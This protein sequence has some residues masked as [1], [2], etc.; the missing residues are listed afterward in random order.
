MATKAQIRNEFKKKRLSLDMSIVEDASRRVC[1]TII[2]SD[3]YKNSK[4]ILAYSSIQNEINLDYLISQAINDN[5]LVY[6]PKVEGDDIFFYKISNLD[7]LSTGSY[8]ILEPSD[9]ELYCYNDKTIILVPGIA[10]SIDGA[11]IGFGKGYYD[12][13]L[14]KN[15]SIYT[16]G[17]AY[18]WQLNA[19][20]DAEM[21]DVNMKMLITEKREVHNNDKA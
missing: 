2:Q 9:G 18:D 12:R 21:C 6:L 14:N 5:K 1:S 15:N 10:F 7:Q 19:Q 13:F 16:I 20:W 17:I 3:I 11:R 4:C 8:N